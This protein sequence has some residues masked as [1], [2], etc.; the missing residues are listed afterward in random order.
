MRIFRDNN[1]AFYTTLT[2]AMWAILFGLIQ[3]DLLLNQWLNDVT[4][5]W[6]KLITTKHGAAL[7]YLEN[8]PAYAVFSLVLAFFSVFIVWLRSDSRY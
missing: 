7:L 6:G 3:L 2:V 1:A 8:R 5:G 4:W